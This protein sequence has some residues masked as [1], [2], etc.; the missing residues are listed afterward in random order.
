M[1]TAPG[2]AFANLTLLL[3]VPQLPAIFA[4]NCF[5]NYRM[6]LQEFKVASQETGDIVYPFNRVNKQDDVLNRMG[7]PR[8]YN[9]GK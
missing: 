4:A 2:L 9:N 6:L 5:H 1:S 3:D 7:R 8:K